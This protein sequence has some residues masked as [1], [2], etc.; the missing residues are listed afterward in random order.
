MN[1]V[2][3]SRVMTFLIIGDL[4]AYVFSL[5]FSL[6]IRYGQIPSKSLLLIHAPAFLVLIAVFILVN[7]IGGLYDKQSSLTRRRMRGLLLRA[8]I[9]NAI[10]GIVF[11][12]FAPVAIA[13]KTNLFIYFAVSTA[14]LFVWRFVMYPVVT[15]SKKQKAIL[16]GSGS[17]TD[18]LYGEINGSL[19]YGLI[20][21]ER[22]IP[23]PD[24]KETI[25]VIEES[26]RR[27]EAVVIVADLRD[28]VIE[29]ATSFLYS[30]IYS[31]VQIIDGAKFYETIFDRIPLSMVGDRWFLENSSGVLGN[32]R[33]YDSLKRLIDIIVSV[34]GGIV[35]TVFY[36][37]VYIAIKLEDK[38]P[39][40]I[41]Q[42]RIGKNNKLVQIFKFRSMNSNDNGK[43][44]GNGRS[45]NQVTKVGGFIR[46]TRI[47]ELPQFWNVFR[48]DM[49]LVGPRPEFPNLVNIYEEHIPYYRARHLVKPGLCGWAQIYHEAHPHHSVATED[50]R[51]KL[52]YDL[53]YIKNR[54]LT[55]DIKIILRTIQILMNRVGK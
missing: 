5:I 19:H 42:P 47:D 8:Q 21:C 26:V 17:D 4:I 3:V 52:S 10:I 51:D 33:V 15:V 41:S 38:G 28:P 44:G 22:I 1:G 37:F 29:S 32:R 53:Y 11:F 25:N 46:R 13:P 9:A 35:S 20:F 45:S 40:F 18:D 48:G 2:P 54:S 30:L 39:I 12:Y 36:P 43:Y 31:G 7:F 49:S 16:I 24:L 27:N 14:V 34:V 50:T 55:L 23:K 6:A